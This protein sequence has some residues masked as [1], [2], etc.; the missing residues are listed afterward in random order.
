M[1]S[2]LGWKK[3]SL[4]GPCFDE[5]AVVHVHDPVGDVAAEAHLVADDDHRHALRGEVLHDLEHLADELRV[6]RAGGLVEEHQHRVHGHGPRDGH[7]LLLAAR[8]LAGEE[9]HALGQA[10]LGEQL[11]RLL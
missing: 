4:G 1:R 6:E 10:H 5:V 9:V 11:V 8:E 2:S 3:T 7:A